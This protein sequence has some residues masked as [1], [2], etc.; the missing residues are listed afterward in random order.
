MEHS[1][2][3]K[4]PMHHQTQPT[5]I[6]LS[7]NSI[8]ASLN[9]Q[10]NMII[11]QEKI[12]NP[13][14]KE[15]VSSLVEELKGEYRNLIN[16]KN[17]NYFCTDLFKTCKQKERIL[18]LEELSPII[19][20]DCAKNYA[21]H[22]IQTL[23]ELS[24]CIIEYNLILSSFEDKNKLIYAATNPNGAYAIQK[25]SKRIPSSFR[26]EFNN[27]FIPFISLFSKQQYGIVSVKQFISNT[28]NEETR[29]KVLDIVK[30]NFMNLAV[31]KYGNY[32]I[33]FLLEIWNNFPEGNEIKDLILR[34]FK[35]LMKSKYSY[36]ICL[37]F[38]NMFTIGININNNREENINNNFQNQQ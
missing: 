13:A 34:N 21:T 26:V 15:I 27:L 14:N 31:D 5:S 24:K 37:H 22:P 11:L 35:E 28:R 30:T 2:S 9:N 32:L 25:I 4:H 6:E 7:K 8:M 20:E 19:S 36:F 29:K 1:Q 23:I 16:D 17:G 38:L 3:N 18:I 33:Q 10:Q 12:K